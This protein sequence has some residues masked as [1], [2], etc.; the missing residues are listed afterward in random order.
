MLVLICEKPM[1]VNQHYMQGFESPSHKQFSHKVFWRLFLDVFNPFQYH[2]H[3]ISGHITGELSKMM[4]RK[5]FLTSIW[6][7]MHGLLAGQ[8]SSRLYTVLPEGQGRWEC[9]GKLWNIMENIFCQRFQDNLRY[10]RT[11]A[12]KIAKATL[13]GVPFIFATAALTATCKV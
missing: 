6:K 4:F 12:F 9:V 13:I 1:L 11:Y 7:Q 3:H 8:P 5:S 2:V 10:L